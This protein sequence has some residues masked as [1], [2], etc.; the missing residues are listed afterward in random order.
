MGVIE[1]AIVAGV[2]SVLGAGITLTS[3]RR[4]KRSPPSNEAPK[5]VTRA[6]TSEGL[7]R[8]D[9]LLY[10]GRDYWLADVA[11][12]EDGE[13]RWSLFR[14]PQSQ[15]A[16]WLLEDRDRPDEVVLLKAFSTLPAG[17]IASEI[18]EGGRHYRLY[19]CGR[20]TVESEGESPFMADGSTVEY[21]L[22]RSGSAHMIVV[23]DDP[24]GHRLALQGECLESSLFQVLPRATSHD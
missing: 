2:L 1:I 19:R 7:R 24:A 16:S 14:A 11:R 10:G 15:D 4:Q 23:L 21:T 17:R 22:L 18:H 3:R 5:Q 13:E 9:V 20:V 8:D 6:S 12:W